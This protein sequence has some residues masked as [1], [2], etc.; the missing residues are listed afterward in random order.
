MSRGGPKTRVFIFYTHKD[1]GELA[2][3][4]CT[5]LAGVDDAVWLDRDRVIGGSNW[6]HYA[7]SYCA[8]IITIPREIT[9]LWLSQSDASTTLSR[10]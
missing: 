8:Y 1:D 2:S 9:R 5:D 10:N 4:L 3:R 7:V 6:S